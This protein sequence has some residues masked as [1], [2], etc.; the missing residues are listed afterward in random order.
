MLLSPNPIHVDRN[1]RT[2]DIGPVRPLRASRR[3]GLTR[4]VLPEG[5][6]RMKALGM[7]RVSISTGESSVPGLRLYESNGFRPA[8]RY[9]TYRRPAPLDRRVIRRDRAVACQWN[10]ILRGTGS[11]RA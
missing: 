3:R 11:S 7:D 6:R 1:N 4:A 9:L 5:M 10:G 8:N 2:G